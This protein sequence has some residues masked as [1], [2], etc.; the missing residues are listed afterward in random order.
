M[1]LDICYIGYVNKKPEWDINSVNPLYLMINRTY[2]Y[3]EEKN[4]NKYLNIDDTISEILKKYNQVFN[5]IKYH[6]KKINVSDSEYEKDYMKIEFN[7]NDGIP[8]NKKLHFL[9][10]TV[11][12]RY[13][14]EK[15]SKYYPQV[16][17]DERVY[18]V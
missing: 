6:I 18:Q 10:T 7:T 11:I 1:G 5:K 2:G 17:L 12:I 16:C 8:L 14:F 13:V 3:V 15:D 9:T 4:G